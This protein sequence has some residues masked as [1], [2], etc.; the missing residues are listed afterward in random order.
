MPKSCISA[1]APDAP[2]IDAVVSRDATAVHRLAQLNAA[3]ARLLRTDL[4]HEGREEAAIIAGHWRRSLDRRLEALANGARPSPH[5]IADV[6]A[7]PEIGFAVARAA[8]EI[9]RPARVMAF[10]DSYCL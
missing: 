4:T 9:A 6:C 1:L 10:E 8:R 3:E 2:G 7:D 5:V